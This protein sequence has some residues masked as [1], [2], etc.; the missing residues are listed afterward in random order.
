MEAAEGSFVREAIYEAVQPHEV[1]MVI[2][3]DLPVLKKQLT[4]VKKHLVT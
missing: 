4:A 2:E 1:W 3:K